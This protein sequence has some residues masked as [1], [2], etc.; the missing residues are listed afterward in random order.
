MSVSGVGFYAT[1]A[2]LV[3]AAL[4]AVVL[5]KPRDAIAATAAL[6]A[7]SATVLAVA[8]AYVLAGL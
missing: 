5:P 2:A 1:A 4:A 3:A 6:M 8:G 7:A